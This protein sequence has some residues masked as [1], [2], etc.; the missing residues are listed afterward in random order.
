MVGCGAIGGVTAAGLERAG[1]PVTPI[2]GNER[3]AA[4][5]SSHGYRVT[6]LDGES[7]AQ[8]ATR[9]PLVHASEL[10][11]D[12]RFD[13]VLV[14]TH[15]TQLERAIEDVR[16]HLA[17]DGV[18]VCCQNGLP[19]ERA[20]RL[21]GRER[22]VGAVVGWGASMVEPGRYVRTS[23]GGFQLGL[24]WA[25][26]SLAA[27]ERVSALLAPVAAAPLADNFAGVRWSKLA[28]N[29]CTTTLGCLGG[30]TLGPLLQRRLVRRIALE[31]FAE[32]SAV[33]TASSVRP[34]PVGGTFD[35]QRLAITDE[36]RRLRYGSPSLFYKHSILFAVGMKYRR[37]RSSM[38]YALERGRPPEI[39]FLNGELVR[40]GLTLGVP[41]PVNHLLVEEGRAIFAGS[42]KPSVDTLRALHAQLA[43][44]PSEAAS[45]RLAG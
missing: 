39:D 17:D 35:I 7:W 38:L 43:D 20:A 40:R 37:M 4:A 15:S 45:S 19:E 42:S 29:C 13:V 2:T 18:V 10:G 31:I 1:I 25:A 8:A 44:G 21:V 6:D 3:I 12:E 36:E 14:A 28:I 33:A 11:A 9:R 16:P 30:D 5:L 41:T 32:V 22:V 24:P 27:V 23:R 34:T 26:A